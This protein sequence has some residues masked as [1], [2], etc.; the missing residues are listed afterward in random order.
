MATAVLNGV[1]MVDIELPHEND[2]MRALA[3]GGLKCE[4]IQPYTEPCDTE[5]CAAYEPCVAD[6]PCAAEALNEGI[7]LIK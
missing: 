2:W 6:E 1:N 4:A 3:W 5:P 7:V